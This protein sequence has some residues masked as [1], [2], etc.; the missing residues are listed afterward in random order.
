MADEKTYDYVI[1]GAGSAGCTL[2][3]RLTEDRD[4]S[5]LVLEA[6]GWDTDPLIGI[7]ILWGRNALRRRHD[8][9]Y[10]TEPETT[11]SGQRIPI[12]RGKVVGGSSSIWPPMAYVRGHRGGDGC[13]AGFGL[14]QWSYA[15]VLPY[16]RRQESWQGGADSY[17]GGDGPLSTCMP[18]SPEDPLADSVSRGGRRGRAAR[19]GGL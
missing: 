13:W 8:W 4:V 16:F 9:N 14:P 19:D 10:S 3:N 2:A 7:P 1:V 6:G 12:Y 11:L 15:H 17:R 18:Q 5:M